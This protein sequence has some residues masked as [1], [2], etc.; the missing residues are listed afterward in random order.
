M[1]KP[2]N[3]SSGAI[4]Q[5]YSPPQEVDKKKPNFWQNVFIGSFSAVSAVPIIQPM[6]YFKNV[7][8]A[9]AQAKTAQESKAISQ[10]SQVK[11]FKKDPRIWYKGV[12][13]FSANFI[14]TTAIQ[15]AA[16]GIFSNVCSP[17]VAATAAGITSA[18]TVCPAEG[19]MTQQQIT[20]NNFLKTAKNIYSIFGFKGFYRA[21]VPT[22][23]RE[24]FFTA[25][26]LGGAPIMKKKIESFGINE[27]VSQIIA[28]TVAGTIAAA[29]SQPFDTFK[30][31]KQAD[32]SMKIPMIKAIF[33]KGAFTGFNW[34]V[35]IVVAATTMIPFVQKKLDAKITQK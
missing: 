27:Y 24:G 22:A 2:I 29:I 14:P 30:T 28:G 7:S 6:I 20:H 26:Y 15:T 18:I 32:F 35:P 8:Q 4:S 12:G 5:Q 10:L 1:S 23:I 33:Q 3:F 16:N 9:K 21:F 25:G 19:I 13:V 17:L 31:Q 11:S 34:R